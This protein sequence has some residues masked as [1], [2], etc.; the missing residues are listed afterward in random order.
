M[1]C[2][3]VVQRFFVSAL[4]LVGC[5][6]A[7]AQ[8]EPDTIQVIDQAS[9]VVVTRQGVNSQIIVN[10]TADNPDFYY[11]FATKVA[12]E[13]QKIDSSADT[14]EM[15][16]PFLKERPASP[17][18]LIWCRDF[19][20]GATIP[21]AEP[22][23]LDGSIEVGMTYIG[24]L[25]LTPWRRGPEISLGLGFHYSQFTLHYCQAFDY[26]DHRLDI[27]ATDADRTSSRLRNFGF[28]IPVSI[29]QP[30]WKDF[31]LTV[32]VAAMFNTFTRAASDRIYVDRRDHRS[33]RGLHQRLVT[34]QLFA[35]IGWKGDCGIY[36]RYCPTPLFAQ[37]WGPQFKT[38]SVGVTI[39]L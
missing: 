35:S 30:V 29:Y 18:R 37:Q 21:V 31:G 9:R 13:D 12:D 34:P 27:V 6:I 8:S 16:F 2:K 11:S 4:A 22:H 26:A 17:T 38:L 15:S 3:Y 20:I 24:G 5:M 25:E 28:Q 33:M 7:S 39:G 1:S 19:Y 32:G 10:G 36:V 14:W 23:G